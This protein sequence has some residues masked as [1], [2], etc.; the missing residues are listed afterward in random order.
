M[1][2]AGSC[3]LLYDLGSKEKEREHHKTV[4]GD[5]GIQLKP[6]ILSIEC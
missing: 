5:M 3:D 1:Q 2:A 4:L 6:G